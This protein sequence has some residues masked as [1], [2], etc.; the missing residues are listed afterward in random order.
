VRIDVWSDVICPWCYLGNARLKKAV[1]AFDHGDEVEVVF[2]SF[3][4]DPG[5]PRD[6]DVPTN[7]VLVRKLGVPRAQIDAMHQRI[8]AMGQAVGIDFQFD[9]VRTSNTFQAHELTHLARARGLEGKMT[10]RLFRANFTE[11]VRIGDRGE[12]VRLAADVGLDAAEAEEALADE[13]YAS[14][15]RDD[16]EQARTLGIS[17]VP[18]FV[19]GGK[20]A[21]SGA[22]SVEV[23]RGMLDEAWKKMA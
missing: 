11:G 21:V 9:R 4:L 20:L 5:R 3:E 15:V 19:A 1:E 17:G 12:L 10:D 6:L 22:Q 16:E 13:R 23:L 7:D 18:F 8:G 14:A 2:R